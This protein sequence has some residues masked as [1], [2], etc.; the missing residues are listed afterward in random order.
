[1]HVPLALLT[2][3]VCFVD[4]AAGKSALKTQSARAAV[5]TIGRDPDG[6]IF[7]LE[8]WAAR[9]STETFVARIF[10]IAERWT[11]RVIGVEANAMQ[12]LFGDMLA[13]E[14]RAQGRRLPLVP[15][16]QP[17]Q[18]K[19]D[20][21]IRTTLQPLLAAGRIILGPDQEA[22]RDELLGFPQLPTKDLVDAFA[23]AIALLPARAPKAQRAD[24]AAALAS[25][26]RETGAP[27]GYIAARVAALTENH[28]RFS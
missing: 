6:Y 23:S 28:D 13:R 12:V 17:P 15:V 27:A 24:E 22:L 7:C 4:P 10:A 20:F 11:P 19:K 26:L 21:R 5:V 8:A 3:R 14:A 25:Y 18:L 2:E 16:Y 1:M 9:C